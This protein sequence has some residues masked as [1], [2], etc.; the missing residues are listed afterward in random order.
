MEIAWTTG[1]LLKVTGRLETYKL[2]ATAP[3]ARVLQGSFL[4]AETADRYLNVT[5]DQNDDVTR[6]RLETPPFLHNKTPHAAVHYTFTSKRY[7]RYT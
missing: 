3:L 1:I 7:L 2:V 5:L 6:A 4:T